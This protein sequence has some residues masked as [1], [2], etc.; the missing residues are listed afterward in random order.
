MSHL[1]KCLDFVGP[2]LSQVWECV[3]GLRDLYRLDNNAEL[4]SQSC[5]VAVYPSAIKKEQHGT[6]FTLLVS[7]LMFPRRSADSNFPALSVCLGRLSVGGSLAIHQLVGFTSD[8]GLY[9]FSIK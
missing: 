6:G 1:Q 8:V 5:A 7:G 9:T 3:P 4:E 2:L